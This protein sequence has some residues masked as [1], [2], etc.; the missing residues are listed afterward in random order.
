MSE[1]KRMQKKNDYIAT[2]TTRVA[3]LEESL[4]HHV[5]IVEAGAL[6]LDDRDRYRTALEE[7]RKG[8]KCHTIPDCITNLARSMWCDPCIA[9]EALRGEDVDN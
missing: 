4:F 9:T 6:L 5:K 1:Y 2:L 8:R 7:I 3:E